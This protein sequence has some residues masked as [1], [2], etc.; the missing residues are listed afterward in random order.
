[1][2][3]EQWLRELVHDVSSYDYEPRPMGQPYGM[4]L[5][6]HT[7]APYSM[8]G[9]LGDLPVWAPSQQAPIQPAPAT[10]N[11]SPHSAHNASIPG[12][13]PQGIPTPWIGNADAHPERLGQ[14]PPPAP[15]RYRP[16]HPAVIP[17]GAPMAAPYAHPY[18]EDTAH[19]MQ[20]AG[21]QP[22]P[23]AHELQW[24]AEIVRDFRPPRTLAEEHE[25]LQFALT[26]SIYDTHR[27]PIEKFLDR[28][29][30]HANSARP[31]RP[32]PLSEQPLEIQELYENE[33]EYL[34]EITA[35]LMN[36]APIEKA[37]RLTG[38]RAVPNDGI[39][40]EGK[41]NCFLISL[42]QHKTGD[43]DSPH[44]AE[45]DMARRDLN[46]DP[47]ARAEACT[48]S[49]EHARL[50]DNAR[51]FRLGK[52]AKFACGSVAARLAV[53]L[54]NANQKDEDKLDVWI[55]SMVD[56]KPHIDKLESG[57]PSARVVGIWDKGG[58]FESITSIP[59]G[60]QQT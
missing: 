9:V 27:R 54:L 41:N 5:G 8:P 60:L 44:R 38:M 18:G 37:L 52:N 7:G 3:W 59:A 21:F 40:P 31:A 33:T 12:N 47:G 58:H 46:G 17:A 56:G 35:S 10:F 1:M 45:V 20:G 23:F 39:T 51:D 42:A 55:I 34:E 4:P 36:H 48:L 28:L 16:T 50:L 19:G 25:Q 14:R 30:K 24:S 2:P 49:Y 6:M 26:R 22:R 53:D 13:Y 32:V 57:S 43:Y 11:V 15:Y 29:D